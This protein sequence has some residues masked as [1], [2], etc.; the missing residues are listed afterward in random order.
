MSCVVP[1]NINPFALKISLVSLLTVCYTIL[2]KLVQRIW[3]LIIKILQLIF[4]VFRVYHLCPN[5]FQSMI[6]YLPQTNLA[7]PQNCFL[8][9]YIFISL[10]TGLPSRIVCLPVTE[11][12]FLYFVYCEMFLIHARKVTRTHNEVFNFGSCPHPFPL[13]DIYVNIV[14]INLLTA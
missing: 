12:H 10:N 4:L 8:S 1:Q 2:M 14:F 3:Y 13:L 11:V 5:W 6:C 7:S 9:T